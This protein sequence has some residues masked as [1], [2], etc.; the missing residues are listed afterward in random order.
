MCENKSNN[1]CI[2]LA[3]G[4]GTRLWPYSRSKKPKQF[5]DLFGI[6]QSMLQVTYNRFAKFM[7]AENIFITTF[8]DYTKL[9]CEQLPDLPQSHIIIEPVQLGTAPATAL[10]AAY[11][12][13]I[14]K[15]AT[16][17]ISPSDQLI[18]R[19][20]IFQKEV[21]KGFDFVSK[22]PDFLVLGEKATT[23]ETTYGYIQAGE[24]TNDGYATLKSFTEKPAYDFAKFF[25]ESGEFY[26]STSLFLCNVQT[27]IKSLE[28][29]Y[30]RIRTVSKMLS[31]ST[32]DE[33]E[34]YIRKHFPRNRFQSI[35][36][37]ILEHNTNVFIG[38]CSFGW[39]DVGSWEGFYHISQKDGHGNIIM[40][41]RTTLYNSHN[42]VVM[43]S[44]EKCVLLSDLD[45]YLVIENE[46]VIM[47]CKK[48]DMGQ[49]RRMMTDAIMK[50]G[51]TVS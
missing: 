3:G 9:V 50:Y 28:G 23:P 51:S 36:M 44:A 37:L 25:V 17:I 12:A 10:A 7:P 30:T 49:I 19:E 42:N 1:Y 29:D 16:I 43:T 13:A 18:I 31:S 21:M 22:R 20:D 39:R 46:G 34:N 6:G 45:G 8:A 4:T 40:T 24:Q 41:P 14:N 5:I 47:I 38:P 11:I 27:L 15:D 48:D 33:V 2:I 35:D 32:T 26:W